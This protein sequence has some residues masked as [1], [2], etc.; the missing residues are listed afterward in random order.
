M[1]TLISLDQAS[2]EAFAN[3]GWSVVLA[4]RGVN[5]LE[6]VAAGCRTLGAAVLVVPTDVG[7][8]NEVGELAVSAR[9]FC[10]EI[11]LWFCNAGV[12][13]VGDFLSDADGHA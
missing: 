1:L 2:A 4:A 5:D 3:A 7:D 12:G 11:D 10:G 9:E 8:I 13:A 6:T